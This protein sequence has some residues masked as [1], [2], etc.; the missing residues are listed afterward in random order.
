M[1]FSL[2][3]CSKRVIFLTLPVADL[4]EGPGGGG[5]GEGRT[6]KKKSQWREKPAE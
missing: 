1:F 3:E 2:Y 4:G 6:K 5:G